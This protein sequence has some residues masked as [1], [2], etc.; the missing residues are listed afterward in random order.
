MNKET[1]IEKASIKFQKL[2]SEKSK[3]EPIFQLFFEQN[4]HFMPGS[5]DEFSQLYPSGHPPHL[6]TLITKP[7]ISGLIN[8]EPDFMWLSSDSSVFS[9]VIIEIEA[10]VKK[11]FLASGKFSEKLNRAIEQIQ[12][13]QTILSRPE[14]VLTFYENFSIPL[15]LRKLKFEP[16]YLLVY[17]R[18]SEFENNPL[19]IQKRANLMKNNFKIISYDRLEIR[20]LNQ[21]FICCKVKDGVYTAKYVSYNFKY[22]NDR[23]KGIINIDKAIQKSASVSA[24]SPIGGL[25]V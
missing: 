16:F 20:Y 14:N 7:K 8:R 13:W 19:L 5:R 12:E 22:E 3:D 6:N 11:Y 2:L 24:E 1:Y 23:Y 15:A 4:P 9:P 18:R 21:D 17:G 25:S 10:P